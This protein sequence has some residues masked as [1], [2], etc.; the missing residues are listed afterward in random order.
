M[1]VYLYAVLVRHISIF[2]RI[3]EL[4]NY[5]ASATELPPSYSMVSLLMLKHDNTDVTMVFTQKSS[6]FELR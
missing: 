2:I 3:F 5:K 6:P 4:G 1:S